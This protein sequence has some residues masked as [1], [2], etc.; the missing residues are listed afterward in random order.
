[1]D[2]DTQQA[3]ET[4]GKKGDEVLSTLT[5]FRVEV[6]GRLATVEASAASAHKRVTDH[7]DGHKETRANRWGLWLTAVGAAIGAALALFKGPGKAG[8]LLLCGALLTGCE[9]HEDYIVSPA[10]YKVAGIQDAG[11]GAFF[12]T[13]QLLE[14]LDARVGEWIAQRGPEYGHLWCAKVAAATQYWLRDD[15]MFDLGGQ[16]VAGWYST[17]NVTAAVWSQGW[18]PAL[19]P[20]TPSWCD[21]WNAETGNWNWGWLADGIGL[22]ALGHELDHALGIGH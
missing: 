5:E 8:A 16:W 2:R 12:T 1:M 22:D 21:R 19:P 11:Y 6:A 20:G 17:G 9:K 4:L 13:D 15:Y 3:F 14:R 10:G 18:G 7:E